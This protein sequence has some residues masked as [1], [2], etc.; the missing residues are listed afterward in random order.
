MKFTD[1]FQSVFADNNAEVAAV[2]AAA[3]AEFSP[4]EALLASEQLTNLLR[5]EPGLTLLQRISDITANA[6]VDAGDEAPSKAVEYLLETLE[7]QL[8]K[9]VLSTSAALL[10]HT[11]EVIKLLYPDLSAENADETVSPEHSSVF[12]AADL[13]ANLL[14]DCARNPIRINMLLLDD[15]ATRLQ[16]ELQTVLENLALSMG[17]DPEL[18]MHEAAERAAAEKDAAEDEDN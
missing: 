6:F 16:K 11:L 2:R 15:T 14:R 8:V 1:H 3:N 4:V 7:A 18:L 12:F 9:D 17:L 5:E 13:T 10:E